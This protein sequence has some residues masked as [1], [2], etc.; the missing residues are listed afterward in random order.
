MKKKLFASFFFTFLY[1]T[2]QAQTKEPWITIFVH[3]T[4]GIPTATRAGDFF[5][6]FR[7][8][9]DGSNY[10]RRILRYRKSNQI[11]AAQPTQEIGLKKIN[12]N[13]NPETTAELFAHLYDKITAHHNPL[14]KSVGYYTFGWS[15]LVNPQERLQEGQ[16][17]HAELQDL[18]TT[19]KPTHPHLKIRII[20]YSH[21]AN[22]ALNMSKINQKS[23]TPFDFSIDEFIMI[24]IPVQ[25]ET[26]CCI[27]D[28]I[29]KKTYNLYSRSDYVQKIDC[30]STARIF[31]KRRFYDSSRCTTCRKVQQVEIKIG[32]AAH[33]D[34]KKNYPSKKRIDRSPGHIELW[35]F[36]WPGYSKLYRPH[37]PLNP[38]PVALFIPSIT[39]IIKKHKPNE[40]T[41]VIDIRP[42]TGKALLRKRKHNTKHY[43][44][45][46]N[47]AELKA[48]QEEA[49]KFYETKQ[50][51]K[52]NI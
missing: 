30:F 3:G 10:K 29:F 42:D 24:G 28:N 22:V 27:T 36:G 4:I 6:M 45:F 41:L 49:L 8:N 34:L 35:S 14:E 2:C 48:L 25:R 9:I 21:G 16:K 7:K 15:G 47:P 40:Q 33:K 38:L 18:V 51:L 12:K 5:T 44:E 50:P 37:F 43:A 31:S 26:D 52:Q 13:T 11:C 19:L 39:H 17:F 32:V 20:G 46:I 1:A 23:A